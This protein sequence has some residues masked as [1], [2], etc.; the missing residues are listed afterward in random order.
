MVRAAGVQ[1]SRDILPQYA[2][3]LQPVSLSSL[4]APCVLL[5][6][7][8]KPVDLFSKGCGL[9]GSQLCTADTELE[10]QSGNVYENKG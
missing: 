4:C 6:P 7:C 3:P 10:E 8:V 2:R 1:A 5:R 9:C